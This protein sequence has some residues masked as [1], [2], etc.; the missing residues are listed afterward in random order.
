MLIKRVKIQLNSDGPILYLSLP[1]DPIKI[2]P[3]ILYIVYL[4]IKIICSDLRRAGP[5]DCGAAGGADGGPGQ[6]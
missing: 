6:R 2:Q 4:L 3:C 5:V 1:W